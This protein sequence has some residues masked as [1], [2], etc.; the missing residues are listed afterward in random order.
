MRRKAQKPSQTEFT[1]CFENLEDRYRNTERHDTK[2]LMVDKN[3]AKCW[4]E[5]LP[6][7]LLPETS[8]DE[9]MVMTLNINIKVQSL[10]RAL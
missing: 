6:E 5:V 8:A 2:K 3:T 4:Y 7:V 9:P 10:N 1:K